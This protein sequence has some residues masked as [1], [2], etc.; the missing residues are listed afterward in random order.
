[1]TSIAPGSEADSACCGDI[2]SPPQVSRFQPGLCGMTGTSFSFE[3]A[4]GVVV[5]G[6]LGPWPGVI[7][8]VPGV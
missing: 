4:D 5:A 8:I 6:V 7:T 2:S 3:P 1:M